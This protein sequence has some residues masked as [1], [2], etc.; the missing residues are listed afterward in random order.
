[1]SRN[2]RNSGVNKRIPIII[3]GVLDG[4]TYEEI[5]KRCKPPVTSRQI[6]R[7][8]QG[9]PFKDFFNDLH[10]SYMQD[11]KRLSNGGAVEKRMA[12]SHRGM[13]VRAMSKAVI[14]TRIEAK[15]EHGPMSI[16]LQLSDTLKALPPEEDNDEPADN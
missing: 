6:Y 10:D 8:R 11:L 14:P 9:I 2:V 7:D 4:L 15:I 1:M 16:T 3:Q 5:G 12:I 13:L